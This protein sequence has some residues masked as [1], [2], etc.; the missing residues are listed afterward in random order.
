MTEKITKIIPIPAGVTVQLGEV[1][2]VKGPKGENRLTLQYPKIRLAVADQKLQLIAEKDTKP[3]KKLLGTLA[4]LIANAIAGVQE[5]FIYRLRA[6]YSHFPMTVSVSGKELTVKNF[7][8]EVVPRRLTLL[9]DVT[10]KVNGSD[11][12]VVSASKALAGQ[13]AASIEQLCRIT[14]RDRRVFQ[15]G[16]YIISKPK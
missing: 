11:L 6:C 8:G 1:L 12:E 2:L 5:P 7:L 3:L 14:N 15:D 9:P 4:A 13:T 16:C 10:V